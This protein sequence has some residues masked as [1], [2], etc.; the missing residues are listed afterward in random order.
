M[1]F[2]EMTNDDNLFGERACGFSCFEPKSKQHLVISQD[3]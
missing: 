1:F 2:P 3:P